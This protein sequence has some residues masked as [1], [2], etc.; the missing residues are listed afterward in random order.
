M[1]SNQQKN[2][3]WRSPFRIV[4][5]TNGA[6]CLHW[7][8]GAVWAARAILTSAP[9]AWVFSE[10]WLADF[11][12]RVESLALARSPFVAHNE[13]KRRRAARAGMWRKWMREEKSGTA[14]V[15]ICS[16][17]PIWFSPRYTIS[18]DPFKSQMQSWKKLCIWQLFTRNQHTRSQ[19]L[20][21]T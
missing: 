6:L 2:R 11:R 20:E 7:V 1:K 21:C 9:A 3:Q 15:H 8:S 13:A 17:F 19:L 10:R 18:L 16:A 12:S 5:K 4:R 14:P